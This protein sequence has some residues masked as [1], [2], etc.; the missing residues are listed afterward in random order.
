M[1]SVTQLTRELTSYGFAGFDPVPGC[2]QLSSSVRD[3]SV[4]LDIGLPYVIN[5]IDTH[6][7]R[8]GVTS[9]CNRDI[10]RCDLGFA[11]A[12]AGALRSVQST[13]WRE[14]RPCLRNEQTDNVDNV[15]DKRLGLIV[16][17]HN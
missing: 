5:C 14:V 10:I 6:I 17:R 11:A 4:L 16:R 7:E 13:G 2:N 1:L 12:H 3:T 9:S 15:A 8:I